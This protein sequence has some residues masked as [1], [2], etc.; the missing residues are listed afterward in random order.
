MSELESNARYRRGHDFLANYGTA[1]QPALAEAE[2]LTVASL[3]SIV[4]L[5]LHIAEDIVLRSARA[6]K[7]GDAARETGNGSLPPA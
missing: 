3:L 5:S 4:L 1:L 6:L 7:L 2:L